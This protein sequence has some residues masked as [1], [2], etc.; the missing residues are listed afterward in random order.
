MGYPQVFHILWINL[1]GDGGF[2]EIPRP[3]SRK[4]I[5]FSTFSTF[6]A[7]GFRLVSLTKKKYNTLERGAGQ[8][9]ARTQNPPKELKTWLNL[10]MN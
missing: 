5:P 6:S 7:V 10:P 3:H 1:N 8:R 9:F 4:A 2:L